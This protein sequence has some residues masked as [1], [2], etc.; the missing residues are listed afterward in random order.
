MTENKNFFVAMI[1]MFAVLIGWQYL[2]PSQN[3]QTKHVASSSNE[4]TNGNVIENTELLSP[5]KSPILPAET[6]SFETS[7]IKGKI[8]LRGIKIS[9]VTLKNHKESTD[10]ASEPVS[11]LQEKDG[12]NYFAEIGWVSVDKHLNLPNENTL[13]LSQKKELSK[14]SPL[15][16]TWDN[17]QG[18]TFKRIIEIDEKNLI[19]LR[20]EIVNNSKHTATLSAYALIR[21]TGRPE[22]SGKFGM[23]HEGAVGYLGGKLQEVPYEK[24][25]KESVSYHGLDGSWAGITDKY[26]LCALI[27]TSVSTV[28][29]RELSGY[30]KPTYQVDC[31]SDIINVA[32]NTTVGES[33]NL[34]LGAKNIDVLDSYESKLS[35]KHFDLAIDFGWFYFITRPIFLVLNWLN[36]LL[37]NMGF[38]IIV[39]TLMFKLAFFPL[40]NKSYHSMNRMRELSPKI[41]SLQKL[42]ANDKAKLSQETMNLYKKEKVNPMGGCLPQLIQ[43]PILF[44]LYKVFSI[45]ID[46]RHSSFL[47]L[48]DLSNADPTSVL[49]LFGL[50]PISLPEFLCIGIL[51]LIMGLTMLIQQ[52]MAPTPGD[53]AQ[54]KMFLIMPVVFTFMMAQFPSGV[55][56]YWTLSNVLSIIQQWAIGR[57]SK[58]QKSKV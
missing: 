13:W 54:A 39:M 14:S 27:P 38:S 8:S 20:Q 41:Q 55:I 36:N 26:W 5:E 40:A 37:S 1:L 2:F 22:E 24:I 4:G 53:P 21:R 11:L 42:Y 19:T 6:I 16:L 50:I 17:G 32:P 18:L 7:E 3:E 10:S 51:P 52:K 9:E 43:F 48:K 31:L 47:W 28:K 23:I 25:A 44:A 57:M 35:I 12:Q 58:Q 56:L 15:I 30:K 34:F 45:S 33:F 29:F 49:T 46:M